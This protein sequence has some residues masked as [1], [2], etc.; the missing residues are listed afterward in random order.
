MKQAFLEFA[1]SIS[2]YQATPATK[3]LKGY[4]RENPSLKVSHWQD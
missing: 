2:K 3:K 4:T 1:F